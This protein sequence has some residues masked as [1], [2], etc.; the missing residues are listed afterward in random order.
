MLMLL[1]FRA[2]RCNNIHYYRW[3]CFIYSLPC[4]FV[5]NGLFTKKMYNDSSC[6]GISQFVGMFVECNWMFWDVLKV[7]VLVL[8]VAVSLY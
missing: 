6:L 1:I 2:S 7:S 4:S 3:F 5:L 8:Y